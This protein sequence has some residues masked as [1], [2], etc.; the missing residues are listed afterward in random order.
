MQCVTTSPRRRMPSSFDSFLPVV[1]LAVALLLGY[2]QAFAQGSAGR[3]LGSVTDQSGGAVAGATVTI[4]DTQ[5]NITRTLMSDST[6]QYNAPN[7][8]PGSYTVSAAFQGFRTAERAGITL[9]VNQELRVDLTLQ[10]GEQTEKITVTGEL[11][12]VETTNS[13][14]GGTI[15][16]SVINDLPLNGRNFTNLLTLRPGTT[17]YA[18]GSG[19][20]QSTNGLRPHDQNYMVDGIDSN[21]PWMAQSVMNA[22]MAAGD[23]GTMLPI[24]AIDEFRTEQNPQAEYGWKP[25]GVINVGLKSGSNNIH[26]T[27]YAYGRASAFDA[28]DF[29]NPPAVGGTCYVNGAAQPLVSACNQAPLNLEQFGASIGGPILK[30]K[31]FYFANFEEQMYTNGNPTIHNVPI[32]S[33]GSAVWEPARMI[34]QTA[35][36]APASPRCQPCARCRPTRRTQPHLCSVGEFS[37]PLSGRHFQQHPYGP[38]HHKHDPRRCCQSRLPPQ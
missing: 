21:D 4:L 14:V 23:A 2:L 37:R 30:D 28:R 34:R 3:I 10:P 5:R 32:T 38:G 25:G 8:L 35:S 15:Q 27:A 31:L 6:G 12:L 18:G 17:K 19:W 24:D 36:S 22:V 26:G 9:E 33:G 7:L 20:T 13:V 29:F 16:N 1:Y 11:P